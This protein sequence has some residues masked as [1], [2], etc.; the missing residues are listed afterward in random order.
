MQHNPEGLNRGKD[1]FVKYPKQSYA[2]IQDG[3]L[4]LLVRKQIGRNAWAVMIALCRAVYSDGRLGRLPSKVA[5]QVT[6]LS[7]Y[8]VARGMKELRDKKIIV[9]VI[10]KTSKGYKHADRSNFG[11]VAQYAFTQEAWDSIAKESKVDV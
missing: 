11:H 3:L 8:Q 4:G 1:C 5:E 9:P 10:R 7:S 6:G 2:T